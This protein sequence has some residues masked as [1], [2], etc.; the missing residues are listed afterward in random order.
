MWLTHFDH[1]LNE[2]HDFN[3]L[4]IYLE[5][6]IKIIL[7]FS[8]N[9]NVNSKFFN[10]AEMRQNGSMYPQQCLLYGSKF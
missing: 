5:H 9:W 3:L 1:Q 10:P 6:K 7:A 4:F 2:V 8:L